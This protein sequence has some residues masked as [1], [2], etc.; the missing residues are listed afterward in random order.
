M[1]TTKTISHFVANNEKERK[2]SFNRLTVA[3]LTKLCGERLQKEKT[4]RST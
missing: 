1:N 3:V 2:Q 4:P